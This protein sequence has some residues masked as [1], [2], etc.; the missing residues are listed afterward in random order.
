MSDT[1]VNIEYEKCL[2]SQRMYEYL[3]KLG[4]N[5]SQILDYLQLHAFEKQLENNLDIL[6]MSGKEMKE[7]L[8]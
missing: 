7:Y 6:T 4:W 5:D 3:Q 1:V 8:D 2:A